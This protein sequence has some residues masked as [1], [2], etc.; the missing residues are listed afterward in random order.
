MNGYVYLIGTTT[1]GWYKIGKSKTPEE[2]EQRRIESMARHKEKKE[3]KK[4]NDNLKE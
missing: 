2:R 4:L 3:L 1:F